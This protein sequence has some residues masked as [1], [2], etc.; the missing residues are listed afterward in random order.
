MTELKFDFPATPL[1]QNTILGFL[2]AVLSLISVS[3]QCLCTASCFPLQLA[4]NA[5]PSR[6]EFL[7]ELANDEK[8]RSDPNLESVLIRQ[9]ES[10]VT[11]QDELI[12]ILRD[13]YHSL[14]LDLEE[15][16]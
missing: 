11:A 1:F 16:V 9:T 5:V 8:A 12:R 13:F 15:E 3:T 4:Q 6:E 2:D 10:Y 14:D 7:A